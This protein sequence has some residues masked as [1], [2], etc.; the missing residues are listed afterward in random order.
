MRL[1]KINNQ[2]QINGNIKAEFQEDI[3]MK[4]MGKISLLNMSCELEDRD[5]L[6]DDTNNYFYCKLRLG[7]QNSQV[8][9]TNGLYS[10]N[11]FLKE[12][13]RAINASLV[14]QTNV[15]IG[16]QWKIVIT[17]DKKIKILFNRVIATNDTLLLAPDNRA[18]FNQNLVVN[19][20]NY[21]KNTPNNWDAAVCSRKF[22]NNGAGTISSIRN[23]TR[24]NPIIVGLVESNN[25]A[26]YVVGNTHDF[27]ID[28]YKYAVYSRPPDGGGDHVYVCRY[29]DD[30]GNVEEHVTAVAPGNHYI[31]LMLSGGNLYFYY[32]LPNQLQ[33]FNNIVGRALFTLPWNYS[34]S[35]Y[36]MISV[37]NDN[38]VITNSNFWPDP[39]HIIAQT[40]EHYFTD[41]EPYNMKMDDV[42]MSGNDPL[43]GSTQTSAVSLAFNDAISQACRGILGFSINPQRIVAKSGSFLTQRSLNGRILPQ[44]LKLLIDDIPIDSFDNIVGGRERM[45]LA[46]P[47]LATQDGKF[48]YTAPFLLEMDVLNM[49][50]LTFSEL[51]LRLVDYQNN[52]IQ[53]KPDLCDI[54][55]MFN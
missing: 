15:H 3:S 19:G 7:D 36:G 52:P 20:N 49:N 39:Y 45:L 5:I 25:I 54:T 31:G 8:R 18:I 33:V 6:I 53:V 10:Q 41:D 55:L 16:F 46:I 4:A 21:T 40:Y 2:K 38:A 51:N 47:S 48:I 1:I 35:F 44:S 28:N 17:S 50:D 34:D 14:C 27:S 30:I 23:G 12:V 42:T 43:I 29:I 37:F 32:T 13:N 22:F 26:D 9:L 11:D 24:N